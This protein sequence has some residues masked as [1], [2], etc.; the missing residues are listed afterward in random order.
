MSERHQQDLSPD[1]AA[2]LS[3]EEQSDWHA[4]VGDVRGNDGDFRGALSEYKKAA[5]LNPTS[6]QHLTK[7]AEGYAAAD[8]PFQALDYYQRALAS[9][10][11]QGGEELVN[12][13]V[14]LGDLC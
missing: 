14:G 13:H 7:L 4:Q 5:R 9:Q 3:A 11:E 10:R 6:P 2:A 1:D 8:L 12:A